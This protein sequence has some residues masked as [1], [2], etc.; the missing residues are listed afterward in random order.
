MNSGSI[1]SPLR[2]AHSSVDDRCVPLRAREFVDALARDQRALGDMGPEIRRVAGAIGLVVT[3]EASAFEEEID[4]LYDAFNPESD[5]LSI[6][7]DAKHG[8]EE[9][10]QELRRRGEYLLQRAN[11]H[12]LSGDQM[13]EAI[14][15]GQI[16]G[17]RV[18]LDEERL[19]MLSVWV[20]GRGWSSRTARSFSRP[21]RGQVVPMPL[22]RRVLVFARLKDDPSI[23]LKMFREI[24]LSGLEALLPHARAKMGWFDR[25]QAFAGAGGVIGSTVWRLSKMGIRFTSI[26]GRLILRTQILWMIA[27]ALVLLMFRAVFG[28]KRARDK[29][30]TQRTR[31]LYFQNMSNNAGAIHT[32]TTMVAQEEQKEA[33][34]AWTLCTAAER[35]LLEPITTEDDLRD[36]AGRYIAKRFGIRIR[37]DAKDA[38][39]ALDRMGLWADRASF[40]VMDAQESVEVLMEH[41]RHQATIDHHFTRLEAD[42]EPNEVPPQEPANSPASPSPADADASHGSESGE[43]GAAPQGAPLPQPPGLAPKARS[44][45]KPART[46]VREC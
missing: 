3:Q 21:F 6:G 16:S 13:Q 36:R 30:D 27:F 7:R 18:K 12:K 22:F 23:H 43:Q 40:R 37:F 35:G 17:L 26:G 31:H 42:E 33:I 15:A 8:G 2:Q 41:Y 25:M 10:F 45:F 38:C 29:R 1:P 32:L 20:R 24:P 9:A 14:V 28:F 46:E 34:L 19:D 5:S 39:E 44:P 4:D 11:F